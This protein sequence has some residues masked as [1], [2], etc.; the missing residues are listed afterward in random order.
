MG[1]SMNAGAAYCDMEEL[2]GLI[3]CCMNRN[4]PFYACRYPGEQQPCFGAQY[5]SAPSRGVASGF[6]VVP[7]IESEESPAFTI[8][9][10]YHAADRA[11]LE[12]LPPLPDVTDELCGKDMSHASYMEIAGRMISCMKSREVSKLV[13]SR[14]I[15]VAYDA[16]RMPR[17]F[18]AL[19]AAYPSACVFMVSYPGVC[20]WIGATP[21]LLLRSVPD[22]YETMALAGTRPAGTLAEWPL[23]EREEQQYVADYIAQVLRDCKLS[24]EVAPTYTRRAAQVEHLCTDFN[25]TAIHDAVTRDL[26]LA[27]LHPTPAVAGMPVCEAKRLIP[28]LEG[29]NRR[30]YGGY[31]GDADVDGHC[32]CFVNLRSLDFDMQAV[33]LYVGGGLTARSIAADEWN[34]TCIKSQTLLS[35]LNRS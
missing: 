28:A 23:K 31:I 21:E 14:T 15:T 32:R 22:G 5:H 2:G 4:I 34:E 7:F 25:I 29:Y 20:R 13:L 10:D 6:R 16:T 18:A 19:C 3:A 12:A 17:F 11:I 30:Y 33:R 35:V 9:P 8:V 24:A 26:L 27:R 1:I